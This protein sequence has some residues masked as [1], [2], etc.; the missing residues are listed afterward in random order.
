[1]L[2][3]FLKLDCSKIKAQL[4]WLPRWHI[5]EA[6]EKTVEWA[7]AWEAGTDMRAVSEEQIQGFLT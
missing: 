2:A 4:G 6:V 3:H 7:K 5:K 1:L